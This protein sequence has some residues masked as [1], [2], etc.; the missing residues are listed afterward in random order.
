[1][2]NAK[3]KFSKVFIYA[4][5]HT[6][7]SIPTH[8]GLSARFGAMKVVREIP[9]FANEEQAVSRSKRNGVEK[10]ETSRK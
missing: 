4:F 9:L 7:A 1:M 3:E 2:R 6:N 5:A 8:T 10:I